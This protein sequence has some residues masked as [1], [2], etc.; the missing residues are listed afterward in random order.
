MIGA[1]GV[2][3]GAPWSVTVTTSV[4]CAVFSKASNAKN[5]TVVAPSGNWAGASFD[6]ATAP[7]TMS[8][9]RTAARVA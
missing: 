3:V 9:A 7:D 1:G 6:T 5:V 8:A 4:T 2:T